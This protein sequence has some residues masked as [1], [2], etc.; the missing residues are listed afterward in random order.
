[1]ANGNLKF[2]QGRYSPN[3]PVKLENTVQYEHGERMECT[4]KPAKFFSARK[5]PANKCKNMQSKLKAADHA[6]ATQRVFY[7]FHRTCTYT[8][9]YNTVS[10]RNHKFSHS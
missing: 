3:N 8:K 6:S 2:Q 1:M 10:C 7:Q 4:A 5:L 9:A